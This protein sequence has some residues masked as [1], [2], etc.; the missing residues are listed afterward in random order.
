MVNYGGMNALGTSERLSKNHR[1]VYAIVQEQGVGTHLAMADL[2][3]LA[4]ARQPSIGFTTVYRAV[5]RLRELGLVAEIAMAGAG[6]AYYEPAGPPH[7]HFRCERC[8]RV[9]DIDFAIPATVTA[10]LA[11]QIGGEIASA[12]VDFHGRCSGCSQAAV[13]PRIARSAQNSR[14]Q[15]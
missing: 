4:R 13:R 10:A 1:L 7:A 5:T 15:R 9:D 8:G 6:S 2:H 3:A 12:I 14:E 11:A